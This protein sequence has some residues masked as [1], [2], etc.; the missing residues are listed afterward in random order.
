MKHS[1]ALELRRLRF[2]PPRQKVFC[3]GFQKTGTTSLQYALS[4]LGYRVG[5][6]FGVG[7]LDSFGQ[8]R[9]R[10]LDLMQGFDAAADNPWSVLFRDLDAAFPGSKFIL[11]TRDPDRWYASA[12]KHFGS[13]GSRMR[14]W[15]YGAASPVGHEAAYKDRLVRHAA[16]VRAHFA[17]RPGDF[18]DFDVARGDGWER[19]CGFL[20]KPVPRRDFPR[21]NTAAM[22]G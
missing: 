2:G 3:V 8:V 17:D 15:I 18:M 7:D 21:L 6:I 16:E 1:V 19:L 22:R 5:G 12:C 13:R 4:L 11:T 10:A 14:E 20:D 9:D